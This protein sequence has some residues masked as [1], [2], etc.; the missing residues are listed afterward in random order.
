MLFK[1]KIKKFV[2][3]IQKILIKVLL[4][5]VYILGF[6]ITLILIFIFKRGLLSRGVDSGGS[7]WSE[8]KGYEPNLEECS[9]ES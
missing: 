6:G 9:R 1:E 7:Y 8:A 4:F 5:F 2:G 3:V